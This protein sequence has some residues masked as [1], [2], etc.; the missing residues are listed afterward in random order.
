[1]AFLPKSSSG[2]HLEASSAAEIVSCAKVATIEKNSLLETLIIDG[3][4][5]FSKNCTSSNP[6]KLLLREA[7]R[8]VG[9][10]K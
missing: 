3:G 1:M 7:V 8:Q 9:V 6:E 10:A 4:R 5:V 2:F